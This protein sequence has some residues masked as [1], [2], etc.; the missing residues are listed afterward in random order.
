MGFLPPGDG[1][2]DWFQ[3][4]RFQVIHGCPSDACGVN[5]Q[6]GAGDGGHNLTYAPNDS[7]VFGA[8]GGSLQVP[9]PVFAIRRFQ[10]HD[11]GR[12]RDLPYI[13]GEYENQIIPFANSA[14]RFSIS[15]VS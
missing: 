5:N 12:V 7:R 14:V 2:G 1:D 3:P 8:E 10:G 13:G 9:N 4:R 6:I 15:R 11:C